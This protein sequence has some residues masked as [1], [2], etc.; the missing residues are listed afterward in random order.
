MAPDSISLQMARASKRRTARGVR[1]T[2]DVSSGEEDIG[3][4]F[5]RLCASRSIPLDGS[6]EPD[7]DDQKVGKLDWL[8][9]KPRRI[10]KSNPIF[11]VWNYWLKLRREV[12]PDAAQARSITGEEMRLIGDLVRAYDSEVVLKLIEVA[13]KDWPAMR[14][15]HGQ[16]LPEIPTIRAVYQYRAELADAALRGGITAAESRVSRYAK[17]RDPSYWERK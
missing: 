7:C 11:C 14:Q 1:Y 12:Y 13:L 3:V 8:S 15:R 16:R 5:E 10:P 17:D 4:A 6:G 9:S 2:L